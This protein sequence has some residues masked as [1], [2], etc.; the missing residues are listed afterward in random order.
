MKHCHDNNIIH[1]DLKLENIL[2]KTD[3]DGLIKRVKLADFGLARKLSDK[4]EAGEDSRGTLEYSAPEMLVKGRKFDEKI[5]LWAVGVILHNLLLSE[6]PFYSDDQRQL[7]F[8]I[9]KMEL[10]FEEIKWEAF[11]IEALDLLDQLLQKKPS[12]R[13]TLTKILEHPF[14]TKHKTK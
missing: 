13:P 7:V 1:H 8:N 4:L 2:V 3:N 12:M 9:N 5:D 11:S 6:F 14:I 10:D